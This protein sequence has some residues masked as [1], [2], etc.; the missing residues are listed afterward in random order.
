MNSHSHIH[1]LPELTV[2]ALNRRNF[3]FASSG[4]VAGTLAVPGL[5]DA[6]ESG[7]IDFSQSGLVTGT[8]KPLKHKEI[9]GFLSAATLGELAKKAGIDAAGLEKTVAEYNK[10]VASGTDSM[11]RKHLP[12]PV[13]EGP[14]YAVRHHGF[15]VVSFAGIC[16]H[17]SSSAS[18]TSAGSVMHWWQIVTK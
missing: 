8:P 17:L 16:A 2:N 4:A 5:L 15:A 1:Q 13:S 12:K 9:P 10:G 11:G 14:F 18:L 6:A 3:V 7:P